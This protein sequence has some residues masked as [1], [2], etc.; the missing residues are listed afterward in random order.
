MATFR[1][2]MPA[3]GISGKLEI[4]LNT[5]FKVYACKFKVI[6]F[7]QAII[8]CLYKH[9]QIPPKKKEGNAR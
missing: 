5:K 2:P 6:H 9:H 3:R 4:C 7:L 8:N 1:L